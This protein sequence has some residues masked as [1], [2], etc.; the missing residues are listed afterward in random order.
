V[1]EC[2]LTLKRCHDSERAGAQPLRAPLPQAQPLRPAPGSGGGQAAAPAAAGGLAAVLRA[3]RSSSASPSADSPDIN[4]DQVAQVRVLPRYCWMRAYKLHMAK[5]SSWR[6]S[7]WGGAGA[8]SR[9]TWSAPHCA[10]RCCVC[11]GQLHILAGECSRP[12][13]AQAAEGAASG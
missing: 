10:R 3:Q 6:A 12:R 8:V 11:A 4:Y 13:T 7:I 5:A 2:L 9:S 1:V